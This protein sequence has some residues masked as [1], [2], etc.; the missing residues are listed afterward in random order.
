[1]HNKKFNDRAQLRQ[2]FVKEWFDKFVSGNAY[3]Q[4]EYHDFCH[5]HFLS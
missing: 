2:D 4:H 5:G 3:E 1:M